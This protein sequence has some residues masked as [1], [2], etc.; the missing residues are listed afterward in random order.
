M[1]GLFGGG[2]SAPPPLPPLPTP[3]DPAVKERERRERLAAARR[4]GRAST[5]VSGPL[6]D[7]DQGPVD[8]KRLL[9]Q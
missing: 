9:G 6:G 5:I 8:R 1:G 4:R 3:E 2:P 7:S